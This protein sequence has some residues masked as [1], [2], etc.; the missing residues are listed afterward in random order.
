MEDP[1]KNGDVVQKRQAEVTI[2]VCCN[3]YAF[4]SIDPFFNATDTGHPLYIDMY[5]SAW[6][7]YEVPRRL[8]EQADE[9][10]GLQQ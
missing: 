2:V 3:Q 8:R 10:A 4:I 7:P 5:G 6:E 9:Q 1:L